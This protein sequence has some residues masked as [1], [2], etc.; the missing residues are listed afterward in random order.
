MVG[1]VTAIFKPG[2][3]R[4][5][6]LAREVM[7]RGLQLL[8]TQMEV[9]E[10]IY[11]KISEEYREMLTATEPAA[12]LRSWPKVLESTTRSTAEGTA[13]LF[14]N[15]IAFQKE[16]LGMMQS[17]MPELSKQMMDSLIE[18]TRTAVAHEQAP[19]ARSSRPPSAGRSNGFRASK[20]A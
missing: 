15:A 10:G 14:K 8:E 2:S 18:T 5:L 6:E 19:A 13:V 16:M 1:N 7:D 17:R 12:L 9:T 20:A 3:E 4:T 11:G